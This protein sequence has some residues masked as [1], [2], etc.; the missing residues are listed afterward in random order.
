MQPFIQAVRDSKNAEQMLLKRPTAFLLLYII[1]NR[2]RRTNDSKFDDLKVGE[3]LIGDYLSY[4]ATEQIYRSDKDFLE[5][6]KFATFRATSKGTIA[7]LI[8]T[9]IF[10]INP[11]PANDQPNEQLTNNQRT[12]NEQLTT[13]NNVNNVNNVKEKKIENF[14]NERFPAKAKLFL[15]TFNR[16]LNKTVP[17]SESLIELYSQFVGDDPEGTR[18]NELIRYVENIAAHDWWSK[19]I[20]LTSFFSKKNLEMT[21]P[22]LAST[23]NG[24]DYSQWGET[25]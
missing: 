13:N 8:D 12:T 19:N 25:I 22:G 14:S 16:K 6:Y 23:E 10:N 3:A 20:S 18:H 15:E 1:A 4:G 5:R 7:K 11:E 21:W 9:S 2:A 17:L 24:G